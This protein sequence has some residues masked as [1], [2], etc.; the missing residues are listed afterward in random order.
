MNSDLGRKGMVPLE[1]IEPAKTYFDLDVKSIAFTDTATSLWF[2]YSRWWLTGCFLLAPLLALLIY[3]RFR[4]TQAGLPARMLAF[5]LAG[6][7]L[8]QFVF[9]PIIAFRYL[10]P[11]PPL[12][13]LALI[14]LLWPKRSDA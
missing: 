4:H 5:L 7:F 14:A 13:I 6:L 3:V 1:L 12:V 10:H 8:S 2:E 11:F 9:S